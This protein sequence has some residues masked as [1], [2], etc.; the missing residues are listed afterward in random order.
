MVEYTK[1]KDRA[2]VMCADCI[3]GLPH[4]HKVNA[5][6]F[7]GQHV[8]YGATCEGCKKF[9]HVVPLRLRV[10][11]MVSASEWLLMQEVRK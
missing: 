6:T 9:R 3:E 2:V 8:S 4:N 7:N 10:V 11:S 5:L 1:T